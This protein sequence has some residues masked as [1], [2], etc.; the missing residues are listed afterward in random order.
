MLNFDRT[1][2]AKKVIPDV[3]V[4]SDANTD[5]LNKILLDDKGRYQPVPAAILHDI[6]I[7]HLQLWAIK[8]GVYQ[9][10]TTEMID[11]LKNEIGDNRAI[12]IAAGNGAISRALGIIGTD[13][14]RQQDLDVKLFYDLLGHATTDPPKDILKYEALAAVKKFRPHTVVGAFITQYG[15]KAERQKDFVCNPTGVKEWE[16]LYYIRKYICFGNLNT[17]PGKKIY[18]LPHKVYKFDWLLSRAI[19]QSQNRVWVWG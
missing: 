15:T 13:S 19:D 17:H 8:M 18:Q 10:V 5:Y 7:E 16:I 14:Y 3:K 9:F 12:E 2:F 6:N 4:V 11:W 1:E